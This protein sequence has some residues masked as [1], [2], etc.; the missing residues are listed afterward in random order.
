M[1]RPIFTTPATTA[2][3]GR[4]YR[5]QAAAIRSWGDARFRGGP[6]MGFWDV[7]QPVFILEAGPDWLKIDPA[8]GLLSGTPDVVGK[9]EVV[10]TVVID[11]EVRQLDERDLSWGNYTLVGTST[12][13][14]GKATQRFVLQVG[15]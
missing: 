6:G 14:T 2:K 3:A 5:Y 11:R 8:T 12:K 13:R 4:E 9:S 7:E 10:I 15:R 1:P